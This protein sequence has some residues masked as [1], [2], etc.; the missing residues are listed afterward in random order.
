MVGK[1][2]RWLTTAPLANLTSLPA[3]VGITAIFAGWAAVQLL[4]AGQA[5]GLHFDEAWAILRAHQ[6]AEGAR[7]LNGMNEYTGGLHLYLLAGILEV[8]GYGVGALRS[9]TVLLNAAAFALLCAAVH[10]LWKDPVTTMLAGALY[11]SLPLFA[12]FG[13]M[14]TEIT[15]VVPF[16]LAA[17]GYL[18]VRA[19]GGSRFRGWLLLGA[20]IL[21]G[22]AA[23]THIIALAVPAALGVLVV[24]SGLRRPRELVRWWPFVVGAGLAFA[25][26]IAGFVS[27]GSLPRGNIFIFDPRVVDLPALPTTVAALWDGGLIYLRFTGLQPDWLVLPITSLLII[28][29][30]VFRAYAVVRGS[31][32]AVRELAPAAALLLAVLFVVVITPAFSIRYFL[33]P[34]LLLP[35][36]IARAG[37]LAAKNATAPMKMTAAAVFTVVCGWHLAG[38]SI[39]L[40]SPHLRGTNECAVFSIGKRLVETS[41][42][43][44]DAGAL[45]AYL[46]EQ[47]VRN[48][49]T[50]VS[51]RWPLQVLDLENG[52]L[53][54]RP[55]GASAA[56]NYGRSAIVAYD[57]E[58]AFATFGPKLREASSIGIGGGRFVRGPDSPRNFLVFMD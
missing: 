25:P 17:A 18:G 42:H 1:S 57:A 15:A 27:S 53:N 45:Y 46:T 10:R 39:G 26:R 43:F 9:A 56:R 47:R 52:R 12:G 4:T 6:I 24:L 37:G 30:V 34:S 50:D 13:R 48:V 23:F 44:A 49:F 38:Q 11:F 55:F 31:G 19:F 54:V 33:L 32:F 14:G 35:V 58:R 3:W 22:L 5:P 7:P 20:G 8:F 28:L 40:V 36:V 51:V 2:R 21:V 41:C 29:T 16:L